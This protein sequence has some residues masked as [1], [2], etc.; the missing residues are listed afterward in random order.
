MHIN[1]NKKKN[2][3]LEVF[4]MAFI[5]SLSFLLP[6]MII[7]KGPFLFFGDY[8]VQQVPFYTLVHDAIRSGN[9]F[10]NWNTDLGANFIGSYS[11]YNLGSPFFWL[12]LPLPSWMVPYTL[13]PLLALKIGVAAVT[14]Y[15]FISRFTKKNE[16]AVLGALLYAFSS[17]SIY[18]I[19]FNHFHE[20]MA[21]FPLL[22]IG[23]E[24]YMV[25]NR[26]G[27]FAISVLICAFVN[28]FFFIGECFFLLIYFMI[29]LSSPEW[30]LTTGKFLLLAFESL[31]GIGLSCI[32]F[33]PSMVQVMG[34]PRTNQYLQGW[35]LLIYGW[36]QR[37]PDIIHSVFFPQ[38]LP[39]RPNFFP[40]SG[41]N[42]SSVAAWLPMFSMIG[43]IAFMKV[44]NGHWLKRIIAV[45]FVFALIPGLNSIFVFFN[46][47]Y[48]GRWFYMAV[49]M[50]SLATVLALEDP[51]ID[52][53][54]GI[55]WTTFIT[56]A[57]AIPIGIIPKDG[58][59]LNNTLNKLFQSTDI[60]KFLNNL[61]T[62]FQQMGLEDNAGRFWIYVGIVVIGLLAT[63]IV[64]KKYKNDAVK[65]ANVSVIALTV[66][67]CIYG[68]FF[69]ATGKQFNYDVPWYEKVALNGADKITL[70]KT[71]FYR[72]DVLN[73]MD[74]LPMFWQ[75]PT[76][77]AFQSIVPN[78]IMKFYP[79][80]GV[81]RDVG[82]R[83]D[84]TVPAIRPLL[85]V[86]YLF[87]CRDKSQQET[88]GMPGW[89]ADGEQLGMKVWKNNDFIPMGFT[90]D[91]YLTQAQ[92]TSSTQKDRLLLKGILLSDD[93]IKKYSQYLDPISY[94]TNLMSDSEFNEYCADRNRY[95]CSSF[96]TD[97]Y[98]FSAKIK[99][100]KTNLV[101][102][103]VPYDKGWTATVNGAPA[104]IEQVD[105]GFMAVLCSGDGDGVS[106]IRF[107]YMT[108]GL[109]TGIK[110]TGVS[111]LVLAGYLLLFRFVIEP[112]KRAIAQLRMVDNDEED[113]EEDD[114][115]EDYEEDSN[116]ENAKEPNDNGEN[117][118]EEK[119]NDIIYKTDDTVQEQELKKPKC[120]NCE[121]KEI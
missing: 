27:L 30:K 7:D 58:N 117:Q 101:F 84:T 79:A 68:N 15:A 60:K 41:A 56:L 47:A 70:P 74:N 18:D 6:Y 80:I 94:S 73:G 2:Y 119:P 61:T 46:N 16:M 37:L 34:N 102:F 5:I 113:Y 109:F 24:E 40:D 78:S 96:T 75:M 54:H 23:L 100:D 104:T 29:R 65:L 38:D 35:D 95:T 111:I 120:D 49:L 21:F 1:L 103:S 83:P 45:C 31:L 12:T 13:G 26:K 97:N 4:L 14:S 82:S 91:S 64:Y 52:L 116:A 89:V 114:D 112:K 87:D 51:E 44:K 118:D 42:W 20:P 57:F 99:L 28:Y 67:V 92:F 9:I 62:A 115:D 10:W 50:M 32:M 106:N 105:V 77:Q 33:F 3:Y 85:S 86:K 48:Y 53:S 76:I 39:S 11:F 110:I 69:I 59:A 71:F 108:P 36:N 43:V 8:C 72:V 121:N 63:N 93:Q 22:L 17:Y 25:N 107:N 88:V 66:I 19:F 90:F 98:G 55:R 81:G